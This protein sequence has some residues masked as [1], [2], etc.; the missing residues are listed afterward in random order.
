MGNGFLK[1]LKGILIP[2]TIEQSPSRY[3]R[4]KLSITVMMVSISLLLIGILL[5][6]SRMWLQN[7]L[8]EE[9]Y[10]QLTWQMENIKDSVEYFVRVKLSALKFIASQ[11]SYEE[12]IEPKVLYTCFNDF[13]RE[14]GDVV[15]LGVIDSDGVMNTYVGPYK[16]KGNNYTEQEWFQK[17]MAQDVYVSEVFM[18]Y[19]AVPHFVIAVKKNIP[20]K[21]VGNDFYILRATIDIETLKGLVTALR[22]KE[23]DDIFIVNHKGILQTPSRLFGEVLGKYKPTIPVTQQGITIV[24]AN[25]PDGKAAIFGYGYIK[26]SP[27]I[28]AAVIRPKVDAA[29]ARFFLKELLSVFIVCILLVWAITM[30]I[31]HVMV[32]WLKEAD[33]KREN[34]LT[35]IEHSSKLASIGRLAAGVAHEINN[36]LSIISQNAGLMKDILDISCESMEPD[37]FRSFIDELKNKE[38]FKHLSNG[39]ID[40]VNRCRTITHR[41]LGFARRMDVSYEIIDV[42]DTV[43]EVI[44]FLEKEILFGDIQLV[45]NF[46]DQIP[47]ITTDKGQLQQVLLNI[48]NNAI[49]SVQRGGVIEISTYLM[50]P[51]TLCISIKD[52]GQ[53]IQPEHLSHI[54]EPFFTTKGKDKGTGLGLSISYGIVKRLG[55]KIEVKS[56]PYK[57]SNFIIELPAKIRKDYKEELDGTD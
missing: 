10:S 36:P 42:N 50:E 6:I 14:F 22:L 43:S 30:R 17:V 26:S 46:N 34:A 23:N 27:W 20:H 2:E 48:I 29:I 44:G 49:D 32:N 35:E 8:K 28:L 41:L 5:V 55:G 13:K 54:F 7:F 24:D 12:L 47:N 45:K 11:R 1:T 18:G 40:A 21:H 3:K 19:R 52:N 37:R 31:S 15:D 25:L 16:L 33:Q 39:I 9:T 57:G 4:I 51:D 38:K 56:L 53:G